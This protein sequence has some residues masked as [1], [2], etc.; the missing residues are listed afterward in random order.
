MLL[1]VPLTV[2]LRKAGSG[3]NPKITK[4]VMKAMKKALEKDPKLSAKARKL[5]NIYNPNLHRRRS[6]SSGV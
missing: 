2:P 5:K 6:A 3:K 4:Q 1:T